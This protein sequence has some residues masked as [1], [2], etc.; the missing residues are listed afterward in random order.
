MLRIQLVSSTTPKTTGNTRARTAVLY[1]IGFEVHINSYWMK[2]IDSQ[3][4]IRSFWESTKDYSSTVQGT[5][6]AIDMICNEPDVLIHLNKQTY[7]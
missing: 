2:W 6:E 4:S 7:D 5:L 1:D 3:K